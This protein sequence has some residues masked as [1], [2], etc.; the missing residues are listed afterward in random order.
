MMTR[1]SPAAA[2][3]AVRLA[4]SGRR[5]CAFRR[6]RDLCGSS[7]PIWPSCASLMHNQ[8]DLGW[9]RERSGAAAASPGR[10]PAPIRG[11]LRSRRPQ[12]DRRA[13]KV[14]PSCGRPAS[15]LGRRT[16][17]LVRRLYPA[18]IGPSMSTPPHH[19]VVVG[20][21]GAAAGSAVSR[22]AAGLRAQPRA[23]QP[24]RGDAM[25]A[26]QPGAGTGAARRAAPATAAAPST[27]PMHATEDDALHV[28][29]GARHPLPPA[30]AAAHAAVPVVRRAEGG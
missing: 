18:L 20:A 25:H 6:S 21:A 13:C 16:L 2:P 3:A 28:H 9:G 10:P 8:I 19:A 22:P 7:A 11:T 24:R 14:V 15:G 26:G 30:G 1:A 27:R 4:V 5:L 17:K 29:A 23:R 12:R